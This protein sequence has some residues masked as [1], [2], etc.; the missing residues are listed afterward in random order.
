MPVNAY[1]YYI[2]ISV[3]FCIRGLRCLCMFAIRASVRLLPLYT[4][5]HTHV[6]T[7]K[8]LYITH[9]KCHDRLT[10]HAV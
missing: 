9:K 3:F 1:D 6:S 4:Q 8:I 10:H 7:H 5:M 2:Y